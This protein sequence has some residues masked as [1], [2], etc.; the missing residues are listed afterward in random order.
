MHVFGK[1]VCIKHVLDGLSELHKHH[2]VHLDVKPENI[3]MVIGLATRD[4]A[5]GC[6]QGR[7]LGAHCVLGRHQ[8]E[9]GHLRDAQAPLDGSCQGNKRGPVWSVKMVR[10]DV[11][12]LLHPQSRVFK[13]GPGE[14]DS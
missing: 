14:S 4:Q 9:R 12:F 10:S 3:F 11:C 2:V 13:C 7:S 1:H 5:R 8:D 6:Q